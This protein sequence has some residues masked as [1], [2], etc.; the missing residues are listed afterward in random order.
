[1]SVG[2]DVFAG[3]LNALFARAAI[4]TTNTMV[5][6]ALTDRGCTISAALLSQLRNGVPVRPAPRYVQWIAGC[7]AV[8]LSYFY[9]R[10]Y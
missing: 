8:P 2:D 10:P 6:R 5:A 1:M 7:F 9:D 3:Q 4:R